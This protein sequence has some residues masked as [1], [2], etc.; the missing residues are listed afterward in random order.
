M[1]A[2]PSN[3]VRVALEVA[4]VLATVAAMDLWA[5]LLHRHFW[6]GPLWSVHRTH[7]APRSGSFE[8]NDALST[9]HAPI[10]I[11]LILFGCGPGGVVRSLAFAVGV[12]MTAFG[13]LYVLVHDGLVH[14][15]LPVGALLRFRA[16]RSIVAAHEV[17]H[18]G[19]GRAPYGILFGPWEL[20]RARLKSATPSRS[21][22]PI[23]R[24]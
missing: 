19:G 9:L 11:A 24:P 15:R 10:A 16:L 17:H 7:H 1:I 8:T 21:R 22:A 13:A 20:R 2:L 5:A 4:V 6:H 3:G 23:A 12:G 14:R 18:R